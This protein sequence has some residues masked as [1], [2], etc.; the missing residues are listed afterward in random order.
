M[1]VKPALVVLTSQFPFGKVTESFLETEI[2]I[3]A[4]RFA[5]LLVLPSHRAEGMRP[6]PANAELVEMD[7]LEDP[8][9]RARQM[10]LVSSSALRVAANTLVSNSSVR[11]YLRSP[12]LYADNLARNV[13]KSRSLKQLVQKRGL[14]R[15]LFYDY[16]LENSTLALAI[17][18]RAGVIAT[19]VCRAHRFDVH[20][21]EWRAGAV[22]FRDEK[23]AALDQIFAVSD[24]A[25]RY[26]VARLPRLQHKV[27]VAHLGVRDPG[28]PSP[29]P[30]GGVPVVMSCARLLPRKCVHLIPETLEHL[31]CPVRWIHVGDGPE[32]ERVAAAVARLNGRVQCDMRGELD[33]EAV[34]RIYAR[35][36]V[37]V[38][39]S[40]ST[41]EGL[42]VSMMEAQS[43]GVPVVARGVGGV[44]E[45]VNESTGVLLSPTATARKAAAGLKVALEPGRFVR[46]EVY[47][48]F[49]RHFDAR[50]NYE[51]FA[52]ELLALHE[53]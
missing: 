24:F 29:C 21:E 23:V 3:L 37:D 5:H 40:L 19:A 44:P 27:R 14:R 52:D 25:Q 18:R 7:W 42:P 51:K 48:S 26:L 45:L 53:G 31:E 2:E 12:K 38:L 16:W 17:L 4:E 15:A 11:P 46:G 8:N 32:R 22:P 28:P 13:L 50:T 35:E 49:R 36:R 33:H 47:G 30:P 1:S 20:D 34:C 10:A 9:S 39:L 41:S 6:L 43:Y